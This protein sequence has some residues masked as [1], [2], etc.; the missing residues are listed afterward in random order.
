M[1]KN[2]ND[3]VISHRVLVNIKSLSMEIVSVFITKIITS[4]R[5]ILNSGF[6]LHY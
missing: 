6:S 5:Y 4:S 2:I 1:Q 3:N